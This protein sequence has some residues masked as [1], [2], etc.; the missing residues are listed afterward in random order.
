MLRVF[1][2]GAALAAA[3]GVSVALCSCDVEVAVCA[4]RRVPL[5]EGGG[6]VLLEVPCWAR[7]GMAQIL[8]DGGIA[9]LATVFC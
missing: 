5:L 1:A 9:G 6:L 8:F 3:V 2:G 7:L 4:A